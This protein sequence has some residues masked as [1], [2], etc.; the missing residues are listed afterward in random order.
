MHQTPWFLLVCWWVCLCRKR[1]IMMLGDRIWE[2]FTERIEFK[3]VIC[4]SQK[5][6]KI[7]KKNQSSSKCWERSYICTNDII[8][9]WE[10][11]PY[12]GICRMNLLLVHSVVRERI[13]KSRCFSV[14]PQNYT[15]GMELRF[16]NTQTQEP[17][18]SRSERWVLGKYLGRT[19]YGVSVLLCL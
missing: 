13:C 12:E 16:W 8:H 1:K 14:S 9:V 4:N 7:F 17:F 18:P 11:Q 3:N 19:K 15:Y 6:N 2:E 10:V 5:G